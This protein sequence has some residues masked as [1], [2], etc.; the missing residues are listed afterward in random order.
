MAPLN[1]ALTEVVLNYSACGTYLDDCGRTIDVE[2]EK[3]NIRVAGK[4]LEDG[5][6][7]NSMKGQL[8][9]IM[10]RANDVI[11]MILMN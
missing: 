6:N 9:L 2:L 10:L 8:M 5:A 11:Q 7:W 3:E 4:V 1:K